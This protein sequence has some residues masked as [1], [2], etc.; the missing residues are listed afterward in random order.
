M[1][2][3]ET[4]I[5]EIISTG[6]IIGTNVN[7]VIFIT[8]I[9]PIRSGNVSSPLPVIQINFRLN[10]RRKTR[11]KDENPAVLRKMGI[12]DIIQINSAYSWSPAEKDELKWKTIPRATAIKVYQKY[13]ADFVIFGYS[14]ED[15][16][17]FINASDPNLGEKVKTILYVLKYIDIRSLVHTCLN[18]N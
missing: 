8:I 5:L 6:L 13:F 12:D 11:R 1:V 16:I 17:P 3:P 18:S 4:H 2:T 10:F 15:V 7:R 9:S 14:T